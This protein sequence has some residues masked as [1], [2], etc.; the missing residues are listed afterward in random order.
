MNKRYKLV[1][2]V[3]Q[4]HL[5]QVRVAI[6]NAGAGRIGKYDNCTFMA[7]GIGTYRPLEGAKPFKGEI[8]KVERAGEA[9]LETVVD[10]NDLKKVIE[11]MKKAHPYEEV[12]YDVFKLED[13]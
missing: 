10:K 2:F 12:A 9:R 8:G 13:L 7:S 4:D 11:A 5:E 3:P 6:C 1:S